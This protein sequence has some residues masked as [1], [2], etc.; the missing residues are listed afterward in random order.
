MKK[1]KKN[2]KNLN[3]KNLN[4]KN[5]KILYNLENKESRNF[6]KKLYKLSKK[7]QSQYKKYSEKEWEQKYKNKK[8]S[9]K[10]PK[11]YLGDPKYVVFNIENCSDNIFTSKN[12]DKRKKCTQKCKNV[13][14][15]GKCLNKYAMKCCMSGPGC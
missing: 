1:S 4:N 14:K 2:N 9:C 10:Y 7:E 13:L 6:F 12:K 8:I 15:K 3:K 5:F 11:G